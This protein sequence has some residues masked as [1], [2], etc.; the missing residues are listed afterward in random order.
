MILKNKDKNKETKLYLL[1]LF[2][3]FINNI[4]TFVFNYIR[5]KISSWTIIK[6]FWKFRS[7]ISNLDK[8][9]ILYYLVVDLIKSMP[10]QTNLIILIIIK[11]MYTHIMS[12]S[13]VKYMLKC[14]DSLSPD[15]INTNRWMIV[16]LLFHYAN[17]SLSSY[18]A[19]T[20]S[21]FVNLFY[22]Y[23][24]VFRGYLFLSLNLHWDLYF[25]YF[26]YSY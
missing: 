20:Y 2:T 7:Y 24:P 17:I 3:A 25:S 4:A 1:V 6:F 19:L 10:L 21:I 18:G 11:N 22:I 26:Y 5:S 14:L 8:L 13:L 9:R 15:Y 23:L 12:F 16:T